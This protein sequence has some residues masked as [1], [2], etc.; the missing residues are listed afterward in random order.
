MTDVGTLTVDTLAAMLHLDIPD[1]VCP[2]PESVIAPAGAVLISKEAPVEKVY[3]IAEGKCV[4]EYSTR[5]GYLFGF[6]ELGYADFIGELEVIS[7]Q[8]LSVYTVIA[9]SRSILLRLP[10]ASFLLWL[11]VDS[12]MAM[13]LIRSLVKKLQTVAVTAS[14]FPFTPGIDRLA[15]FILTYCDSHKGSFPIVVQAGRQNIADHLGVNV[16]TVNRNVKKLSE[17]G[18]LA[19]QRGKIVVR[20]EH[21]S[22][23]CARDT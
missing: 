15:R 4:V 7:G 18:C 1:E 14:Q 8:R 6:T 21:L 22:A 11:K 9:Q 19:V 16:R 3:I 10:A 13:M 2:F 5:S 20:R 17:A 12:N 23:L